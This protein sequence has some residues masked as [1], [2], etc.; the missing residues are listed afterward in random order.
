MYGKRIARVGAAAL[1]LAASAQV[2]AQTGSA[3]SRSVLPI[4]APAFDG[5]IAQ[6]VSDARPASPFRVTAPANA[7]NVFLFMSDDVGLA[8]AST[9]GGPVP[10]P[11]LDRIAQAGVRF[12]QFHTTG[13]CSPSRAALLTGRNHHNVGFG[14]LADLP[15]GYPG[16]TAQ[17]P[18][19]TAPLAEIL[20][21]NGYNTAMFGKTHNVRHADASVAGPFDQWPTGQ[22]FEYFWGIVGGDSDQYQP[23]IYRG[24]TRLPDVAE[25]APMMEARMAS[26]AIDWVHNQQ[27]AAPDKP[28]F[29]Y[30]APGS[31]HAPHQ[32]PADWIARF[33]GRFDGG[34]DA[35]RDES[36]ARMK[37]QGVIPESAQLTARPAEIV[38]WDSLSPAR[39]R[40]AARSMEVAAAMLAY[41][42]AQLGRVLDELERSG[43]GRNLLTILVIG[44]N[45]ASAES[46][47]EGTLNELG[48]I[49][50]LTEDEAWL[51][52]NLDR[53]GGPMTYQAYPA[54]WAWAMNTPLRWTKQYASM[55]GGIRNGLILR[56][57]ERAAAPGSVCARFGHLVDI[58]PTILEAAQL[59]V[60]ARVNG[61]AQRPM[62]GRSLLSTLDACTPDHTR[63]Q[64]FEMGG[65][66]GLW[67]DGWFLA[68]DDGRTPWMLAP[69][70]DAPRDWQLY[71]LREDYS[72]SRD[73]AAANPAKVAEMVAL[74]E[75]EA[76]ANHVYPLDH[77]FGFLR[78]AGHRPS[79]RNQFDYWAKGVSVPAQSGPMFAG[80]SFTLSAEIAPASDDAS[81]VVVAYGSRFAGWSL[82]LDKG[83]PVFTYAASTHPDDTVTIR[84]KGRVDPG[85]PLVL[86]L[87]TPGPRQGATISLR[88]GE[89]TLASGSVR[90]TFL[91]PAGLGET[92]DLGRD[93]G[94]DV[95]AYPGGKDAF[96]GEIPHV[97]ITLDPPAA[98]G[99]H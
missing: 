77:R 42:D 33:S 6:D 81:G 1:A 28:F 47:N 34:W 32:A 5:S 14:H 88:S 53:M 64:Y 83:R 50:G 39:Q 57:N 73:V 26:E 22:G 59:P 41:Q 86:R 75:R 18:R 65:K 55:L 40:F 62:D 76:E 24:T 78:A 60:P 46:G 15:A 87:E 99:A 63:T 74:W 7:P 2:C 52:A 43:E 79:G 67:H 98:R 70:A 58:A 13:I 11:N 48:K 4:P 35:M 8:M 92:L 71:N 91:M 49:N 36:F 72:Q 69:P 16:Y 84:A 82:Y 90:S 29:L 93:T 68:Q 66:I 85:K 10:T 54:G 23:A 97:A 56:W 27:A 17:I 19:E 12:N 80:R 25:D 61:V 51:T 96:A 89:D 44:D 95:T 37:A 45:G 38:A 30:Y 3:P 31:T 9:F 20:K 21:L 94:V